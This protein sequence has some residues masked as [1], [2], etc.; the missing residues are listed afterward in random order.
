MQQFKIVPAIAAS[1][2]MLFAASSLYDMYNQYE[3]KLLKKDPSAFELLADTH[4]LIAGFK[5]QA[6]WHGEHF[7]EI[8]KQACGGHGYL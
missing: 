8:L 3:A 1:W 2:T 5:G 4:A 7:G 6:T